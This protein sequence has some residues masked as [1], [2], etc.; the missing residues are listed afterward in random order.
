MSVEVCSCSFC[1]NE[2]SP[3]CCHFSNAKLETNVIILLYNLII[4]TP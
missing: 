3:Q 4:L 1:F 2:D